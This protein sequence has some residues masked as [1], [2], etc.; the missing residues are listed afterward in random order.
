MEVDEGKGGECSGS[1]VDVGIGGEYG[2]R[3][4]CCGARV[5]GSV[6]SEMSDGAVL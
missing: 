5:V 3:T 2:G 1:E 4:I 6:S